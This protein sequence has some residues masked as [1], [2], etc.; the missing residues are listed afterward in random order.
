MASGKDAGGN[1][2]VRPE[3][4]ARL[5]AAVAR[6]PPPAFAVVDGGHFDNL[7]SALSDAGLLARSLFLGHGAR[8]VEQ[9]GPWLVPVHHDPDVGT[10]LGVVGDLPA[11]V[12]WSCPEGEVALY[13]HLRRLNRVRIPGWA[14]AG[15]DGPEPGMDA[16]RGFEAV[17]F[18]HWDP[19]V[20]G[21]LLPVLDEGQFSRVVRPAAG[22]CFHAEHHG[23]LRRVVN[24]PG[25][26]AAP[27]GML[28]IRP[29]QIEAL[30]ERRLTASHRRV[31]VYL[32][33]VF[34]EA[35]SAQSGQQLRNFVRQADRSGRQLGLRT[36]AAHKRWAYLLMASDGQVARTPGA[37]DF[38]RYGGTSPDDQVRR[39][40]EMIADR[41]RQGRG[42][43]GTAS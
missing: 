43:M 41:I 14:A 33:D 19:N 25:W 3:G 7:P 18:R 12:F 36:E 38:I 2:A 6:M 34:P 16:D 42:R 40:V 20:L 26:P 1:E 30:A 29:E 24:D 37:L 9:H 15:K 23:G 39:M 4:L 10:V 31:A 21:A 22:L 27:G 35:A 11:V 28:S 5:A 32:H 13:G 17:L 8:D